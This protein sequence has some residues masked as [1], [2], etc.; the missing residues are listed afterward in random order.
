MSKC[1]GCS[2]KSTLPKDS[3]ESEQSHLNHFKTKSMMLNFRKL[4]KEKP[5]TAFA[6]PDPTSLPEVAKSPQLKQTTPSSTSHNIVLDDRRTTASSTVFPVDLL[7]LLHL[8][9]A[10]LWQFRPGTHRPLLHL[11]SFTATEG[12]KPMRKIIL[13]LA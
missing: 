5:T 1:P 4:V 7:H 6:K 8:L 12:K 13:A 10:R 9:R 2:H 11:G 3:S